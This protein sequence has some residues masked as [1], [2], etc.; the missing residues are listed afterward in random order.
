MSKQRSRR[1]NAA[2]QR[3]ASLSHRPAAIAPRRRRKLTFL[4]VAGT[5]GALALG[6]ALRPLLRR[7]AVPTSGVV[8]VQG[9]MAG[10]L[11]DVIHAKAGQPITIR[12]ESLDTSFHRDGGGHH[13]FAIDELGVNL[14]APPLGTA[15]TTFVP[16]KAGV[17]DFYCS[18]CCGGKANPTMWGRLIV[19]A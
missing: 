13:Q 17:Y 5:A 7:N 8:L 10:F 14:I 9:T 12:L 16:P 11:P 4:L 6:L 15:E 3:N 18:I 19:E 2:A 1:A